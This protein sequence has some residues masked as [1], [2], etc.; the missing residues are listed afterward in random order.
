M[1]EQKLGCLPVIENDVLKG[2]LTEEDFVC[3]VATGRSET[4]SE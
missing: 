2:I 1:I 4:I 3:W